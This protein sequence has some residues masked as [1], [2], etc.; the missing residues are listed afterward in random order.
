MEGFQLLGVARLATTSF[1]R[2]HLLRQRRRF[3]QGADSRACLGDPK[4]RQ[5]VPVG[6]EANGGPYGGG[7]AA[8]WVLRRDGRERDRGTM[9]P[10]GAGAFSPVRGLLRDPLRVEFEHGEPLLRRADGGLPSV[11]RPGHQRQ[12]LGRRVWN[13]GGSE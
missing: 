5:A 4:Q 3:R 8:R 9:V 1:R 10:T 6:G 11:G 12:V 7:D 13:C 2:L